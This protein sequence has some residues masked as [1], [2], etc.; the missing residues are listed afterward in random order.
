MP[1]GRDLSA[2][3]EGRR[4]KASQEGTATRTDRLKCADERTRS[5]GREHA[6]RSAHCRRGDAR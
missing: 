6:S 5:R 2:R 3:D 4:P 1:A